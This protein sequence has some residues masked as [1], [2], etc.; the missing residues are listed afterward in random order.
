MPGR[1]APIR[2]ALRHARLQ[3]AIRC[4]LQGGVLRGGE[5]ESSIAPGGLRAG[6]GQRC[7]GIANWA[8]SGI[9]QR[10]VTALCLV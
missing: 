4:G 2:A 8:P 1:R 5:V 10:W 7:V 6:G 9:S 3:S